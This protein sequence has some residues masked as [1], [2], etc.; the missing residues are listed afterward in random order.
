MHLELGLGV[1]KCGQGGNR[2]DLPIFQIESRPRIDV[3][4]RKFNQIAREIGREIAEAFNN[5]FSGIA[6]DFG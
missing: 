4:K 3:S 2:G 6:V 5:M 1:A